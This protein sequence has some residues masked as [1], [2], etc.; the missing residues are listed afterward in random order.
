MSYISSPYKELKTSTGKVLGWERK[1]RK[2]PKKEKKVK[3]S[4]VI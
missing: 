3:Q 2:D 1:N 4:T